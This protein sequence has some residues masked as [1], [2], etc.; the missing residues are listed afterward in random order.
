[1]EGLRAKGRVGQAS[2][3]ASGGLSEEVSLP[4]LS[5]PSWG[6]SQESGPL[7]VYPQ[8]IVARAN[9]LKN[10]GVPDD[11][12]KLDDL[13]V[14]V[15]GYPPTWLLCRPH[16][17]VPAHYSGF[18]SHCYPILQMGKLRLRVGSALPKVALGGRSLI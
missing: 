16:H 15:S 5:A 14:L 6:R 3:L 1:M 7:M 2:G 10:S 4:E 9:S 8:A 11:I 13:S 12:F 17:L 18:W